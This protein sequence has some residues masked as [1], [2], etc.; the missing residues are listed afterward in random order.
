M[1]FAPS[2]DRLAVVV[3]DAGCRVRVSLIGELDFDETDRLLAAVAGAI[4]R[5]VP[6]HV[7]LD[8]TELTF[9]DSA[10]IR[11]LLQCRDAAEQVG[12]GLSVE[13]VSPMVYQVL[14]ITELVEFL[15]V[16]RAA[17]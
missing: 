7:V 13:G 17:A 6:A 10:G 16:T 14:R 8:A 5:F 1:N 4:D 12:A 15:G 9:L 3:G 11:A 2:A